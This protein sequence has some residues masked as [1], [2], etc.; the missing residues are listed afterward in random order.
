MSLGFYPWTHGVL[1]VDD[2]LQHCRSAA[3]K[4]RTSSVDS[5]NRVR[6]NRKRRCRELRLMSSVERTRTK[7]RRAILEDHRTSGCASICR[8]HGSGEGHHFT[9]GGGVQ[10]RN[11]L[12]CR[13]TNC[14]SER[15]RLGHFH[16]AGFVRAVEGNLMAANRRHSEWFG[17][18]LLRPAINLVNDACNTAES[19]AAVDRRR[20]DAGESRNPG[21]SESPRCRV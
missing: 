10:G 5:G 12:G 20:A 16:V 15:N 8:R 2:L 1:R 11:N 7:C 13:G 6:A 17:V 21:S 19:I 9:L 14:D 18:G 4:V 3:G